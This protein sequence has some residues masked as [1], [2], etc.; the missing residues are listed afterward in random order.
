MIP[1]SVLKMVSSLGF[2]LW[3]LLVSFSAVDPANAQQP[4]PAASPTPSLVTAPRDVKARVTETLIDSSISDEP[5]VDQ[6]LAAY[7]PKVRALDNVIG[8]LKGELRKGGMG[9]GS[10]GNFVADGMRAQASAKLGKPIDLAIMNGGGLRRNTISE[11]ELRA[12]DI[13]ELLPFENALVTLDLSGE[14]ILKLLGV[15]VSSREAQSG[16]RLT[17]IIKADKSSQLETAML[18]DEKGRDQEID[19]KATYTIVTIDYLVNVGGERYSVLREGRNTK[20][21]GITL[22]DAVM[23]YVKSETAATREIK[24][25]LDERFILD[26]ANSVMSGEAPPK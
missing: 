5:A 13:F 3:L 6:M 1:R 20:P 21:V 17:Y 7:A 19:P 18:R 14:Q 15:V 4:A 25:R 12:R 24:P 11:G 8:K 26:R 22:R 10:L 23:D 16:A 9:A 2:G